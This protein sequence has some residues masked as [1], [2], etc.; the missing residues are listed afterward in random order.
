VVARITVDARREQR[1]V[2]LLVKRLEV[3]KFDCVGELGP[4]LFL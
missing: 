4:R 3:G 2:A 1:A